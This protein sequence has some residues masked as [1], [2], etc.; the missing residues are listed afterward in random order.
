MVKV[1]VKNINF[2]EKSVSLD[3]G[4]VEELIRKLNTNDDSVILINKKGE[5][6][7]KDKKLS[8]GEELSLVEV[9]SGG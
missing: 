5:I 3:R 6:Y 2:G 4:N 7:T 9:F 8:E 1:L